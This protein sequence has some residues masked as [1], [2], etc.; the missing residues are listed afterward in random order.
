M[1]LGLGALLSPPL[2]IDDRVEQA[3]VPLSI[4]AEKVFPLSILHCTSLSRSILVKETT[5]QF[6][7]NPAMS[8]I[9]PKF[10]YVQRS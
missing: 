6:A 1:S 3:I 7:P 4:S 5:E 2:V 10:T 8:R 9:I